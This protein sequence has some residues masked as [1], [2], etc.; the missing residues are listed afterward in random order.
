MNSLIH[1]KRPSPLRTLRAWLQGERAVRG[2][3][4]IALD[5]AQRQIERE[6][7]LITR[8]AAEAV[9]IENRVERARLAIRA[10]L[11]DSVTPGVIDANEASLVTIAVLGAALA[12]ND[13]NKTIS[14]LL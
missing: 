11:A 6:Q 1:L 9:E 3:C 7:L 13:H 2:A 4:D 5:V 12:A 10:A 14:H 8:V